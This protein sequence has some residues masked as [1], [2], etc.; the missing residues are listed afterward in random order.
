MT[1]KELYYKYKGKKLLFIHKSNH[2]L[3]NYTGIVIGYSDHTIQAGSV[4]RM[5]GE[6]IDQKRCEFNLS[7]WSYECVEHNKYEI[8]KLIDKLEL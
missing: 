5:D 2:W 8:Q 3:P 6:I 4:Q 1:T 7:F